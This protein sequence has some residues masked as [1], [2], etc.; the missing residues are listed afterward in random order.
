MATTAPFR[1]QSGRPIEAP[2]AVGLW[3]LT[4]LDAPTV[5]VV[6]TAGIAWAAHVRL[7]LWL[8]MVIG[9]AAWSFYIADRLLDA[10]SSRGP[11]RPRHHFHW[12]HRFLFTPLAIAAGVAAL[13][14]VLH[15]MPLVARERNSILAAAAF[16]YFTSVHSP[17][18]L[19]PS[20]TRLRI[21]K[22]LLVGILFTVACSA[23][24]WLR[25]QSHRLELLPLIACFIALAWLNC[26]AIETWESSSGDR[27]HTGVSA[28]AIVIV[29]MTA[30]AG[31][32]EVALHQ[33]RVAGL[34]AAV[35]VSGLLLAVL[36][37]VRHRLASVA[38]RAA[39]DL[40]LLTPLALLVLQ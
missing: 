27:D 3:H 17:W 21:P 34:L 29:G 14:M 20:K 5:A 1:I 35:V 30:S 10:R 15:S 38:L 25:M 7:P 9:L 18:R 37:R 6:W 8:F 11:L 22:E 16:A 36:D 31:A 13:A 26:Y 4:S 33:P 2:A 23:P 28:A 32:L 19:P 40:A 24:T 12:R 39:A